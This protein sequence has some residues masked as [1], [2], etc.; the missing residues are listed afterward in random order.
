MLF[1]HPFP[2]EI[3][4]L[5]D[6]KFNKAITLFSTA[7]LGLGKEVEVDFYGTEVHMNILERFGSCENI[8]K[9]NCFLRK[10]DDRKNKKQ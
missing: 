2:F 5:L 6:V 9:R 1:L 7:A 10:N 8:M 3:L 4:N